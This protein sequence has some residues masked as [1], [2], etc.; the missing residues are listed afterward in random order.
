MDQI[1]SAIRGELRAPVADHTGLT[2][3]YDVNLLFMSERQKPREDTELL[4]R[5]PA[6]LQSELGLKLEKG[7]GPAEVLVI[8][9][10]EKP[11]AN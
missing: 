7:K 6:A 1:V 8:D 5:L 9:H 10:I 11:S 2:G 3:L 4:Q